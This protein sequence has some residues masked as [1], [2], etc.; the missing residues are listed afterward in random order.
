MCR[1]LDCMLLLRACCAHILGPSALCARA[2]LVLHGPNSSWPKPGRT[3]WP[4]V[5]S[6]VEG[7]PLWFWSLRALTVGTPSFIPSHLSACLVPRVPR[8]PMPFFRA[9]SLPGL[10]GWSKSDSINEGKWVLCEISLHAFA[11]GQAPCSWDENISS[12]GRLGEA[13]CLWGWRVGQAGGILGIAVFKL[14]HVW[15]SLGN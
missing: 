4:W 11:L 15:H 2:L 6:L 7:S 12:P 1:T 3:W 8:F 14:T 5:L 9:C 13:L 10:N